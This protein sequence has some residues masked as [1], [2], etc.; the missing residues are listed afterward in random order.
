MPG[1]WLPPIFLC[2]E[3]DIGAHPPF[4]SIP[5]ILLSGWV[6]VQLGITWCDGEVKR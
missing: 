2:T 1:H 6:N 5:S 3:E 4:F